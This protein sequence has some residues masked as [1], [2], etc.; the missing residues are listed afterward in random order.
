MTMRC[1]RLRWHPQRLAR[2]F[3]SRPS[4][5]SLVDGFDG[6]RAFVRR[7]HDRA[8]DFTTYRRQ[9][10][11]APFPLVLSDLV[12]FVQLQQPTNTQID[13]HEFLQGATHAYNHTV[14]TMFSDEFRRFSIGTGDKTADIAQVEAALWPNCWLPH[15][16]NLRASKDEVDRFET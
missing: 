9:E 8:G 6:V 14:R 11:F 5:P 16:L 2:C 7:C 3:S 15:L 4:D 13:L 12:L 10:L 1:M